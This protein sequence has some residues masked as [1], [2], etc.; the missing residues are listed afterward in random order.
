MSNK[1]YQLDI[2]IQTTDASAP[3]YGSYRTTAPTVS[4]M[5]KH[6]TIRH[7]KTVN[8]L[9]VIIEALAVVI[10]LLESKTGVK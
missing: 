9:K 10:E 5:H 7:R 2:S 6:V 1:K 8:I 4:V 3:R